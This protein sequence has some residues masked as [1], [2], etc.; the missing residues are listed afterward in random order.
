MPALSVPM[1]K[2]TFS[3]HHAESMSEGEGLY[4]YFEVENVNETVS[5]LSRKGLIFDEMPEAKS[6][7]WTEARLRD[8]DGNQIIIYNAG[9]NRKN[10]PWRIN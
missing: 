9:K 4:V 3:V 2:S 1:A 10:P 5:E 7:L 8:P 6:W